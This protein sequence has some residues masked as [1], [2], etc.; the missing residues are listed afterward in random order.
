MRPVAISDSFNISIYDFVRMAPANFVD[1]SFEFT[2]DFR[3]VRLESVVCGA[4]SKFHLVVF[5]GPNLNK[6]MGTENDTY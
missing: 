4:K 2:V 6:M 1:Y 3:C 5:A